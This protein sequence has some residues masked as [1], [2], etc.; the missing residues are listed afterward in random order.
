ME[1]ALKNKMLLGLIWSM[2]QRFGVMLISF[3][4]NL[5]L[6]RL[7]TP[8]D[9]G[10]IGMLLIF[11]SISNTFIDGGFGTAL[12]QKKEPTQEDYSTIFYWNV[13]VSVILTCLL[14]IASPYISL[15]YNLPL[16]TNI[17]RVMGIVLIINA[18][19]VIQTN[20]L[21]KSYNLRSWQLLILWQVQS[22]RQ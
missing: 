22:L 18:F 10:T 8:E 14:C 13:I 16:L 12:V 11:I 5:I 9:Y 7:L 2:I 4:S 15:F 17:L 3:V 6:A 21:Q 19:S 1:V 20:I